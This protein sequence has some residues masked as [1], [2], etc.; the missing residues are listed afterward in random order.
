MIQR[1]FLRGAGT[2]INSVTHYEGVVDNLSVIMSPCHTANYTMPNV[3]TAVDNFNNIKNYSIENVLDN[4]Q[5]DTQSEII[6]LQGTS[7]R[8]FG[9]ILFIKN[10]RII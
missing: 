3:V 7:S 6:T 1:H 4:L 5:V 8:F 2:D 10:E 9:P